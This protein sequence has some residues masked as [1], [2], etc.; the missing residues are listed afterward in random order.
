MLTALHSLKAESSSWFGS[1]KDF[2]REVEKTIGSCAMPRF[3][4]QSP[5]S[6][7]TRPTRPPA[8]P[9][10]H[11]TDTIQKHGLEAGHKV[12]EHGGA[13]H[14]FR[15]FGM[16]TENKSSAKVRAMAL[17]GIEKMI[18]ALPCTPPFCACHPCALSSAPR[19]RAP[20]PMHP[21][22]TP[23]AQPS[24]TSRATCALSCA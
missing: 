24:S 23:A 4:P 10:S 13:D 21:S 1:D 11:F 15:C 9:P 16:A 22:T 19:A 5:P 14:Y 20:H 3:P 6:S 18:C 8:H 17:D 7:D 2:I 12:N